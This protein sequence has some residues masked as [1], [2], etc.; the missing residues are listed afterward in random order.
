MEA[1]KR[2]ALVLRGVEGGLFGWQG[3]TTNP[4]ADD[5]AYLST[6]GG[7][8]FSAPDQNYDLFF[9]AFVMPPEPANDPPVA[10]DDEATTDEDEAKDIDVLA[11]DTDPDGDAFGVESFTDLSHGQVTENPNGV[12]VRARQGLQRGGLLHLY[13]E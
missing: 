8:T 9:S 10:Q 4:C 12:Q 7:R 5:Q 6:D 13:G 2:Y 1:G 3:S 11:N